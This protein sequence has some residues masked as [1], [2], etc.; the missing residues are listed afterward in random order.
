MHLEKSETLIEPE[1]WGG[2]SSII[3]PVVKNPG[4]RICVLNDEILLFL[5][6]IVLMKEK[7]NVETSKII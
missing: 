6:K 3:S 7:S 4:G 5:I 1:Q 2:R